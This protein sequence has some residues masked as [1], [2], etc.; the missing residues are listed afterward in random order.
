MSQAIKKIALELSSLTS[1]QIRKKQEEMI[2][3]LDAMLDEEQLTLAKLNA[4]EGEL[5]KQEEGYLQKLKAVQADV[6]K[7]GDE[8]RKVH[9]HE[10]K[11][12]E[13]E[14][15]LIERENAV[16]LREN[17]LI[18]ASAI[19]TSLSNIVGAPNTADFDD[20]LRQMTD[21]FS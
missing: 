11:L 6:H 3:R 9:E 13:R 12:L 21:R 4:E 10:S 17:D 18:F 14:Q 2:R 5:R 1:E 8:F 19:M 15:A 7:L 16:A 20:I